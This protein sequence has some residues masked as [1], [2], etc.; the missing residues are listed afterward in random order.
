MGQLLLTINNYS[1]TPENM[2]I[3]LIRSMTTNLNL[4]LLLRTNNKLTKIFNSKIIN[5]TKKLPNIL[6][7]LWPV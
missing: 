1:I 4:K 3:K 7:K 2:Y 6:Y 5:N